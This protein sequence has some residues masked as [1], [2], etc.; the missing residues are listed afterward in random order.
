M[1][2]ALIPSQR[3]KN[4]DELNVVLRRAYD[5]A[6]REDYASGLALCDWLIDDADTRIAGLRKRAAIR[7]HQDHI[8]EAIADLEAVIKTGINEPA[9]AHALGLMYL[10]QQK[11][12]QATVLLRSGV[13]R[14]EEAKFDY[15]LNPCRILLGYSLIRQRDFK[16]A[17]SILHLL[18]AGYSTHIYGTGMK[19][20]EDLLEQVS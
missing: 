15:Y 18:P 11:Y 9:D 16:E 3:P 5:F 20:K 1:S 12:D 8:D 4:E 10:L 2:T 19:S 17:R 13:A 14:C 6:K 7:E